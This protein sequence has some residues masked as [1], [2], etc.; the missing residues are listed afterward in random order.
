MKHYTRRAYEAY[1]TIILA[2]GAFPQSAKTIEVLQAWEDNPQ[3]KL[4]ACCDGAVNS[5]MAYTEHLPNIV[6]GDLD[7]LSCELRERLA[8]RLVHIAEQDTN[9]LAKTLRHLS[10]TLGRRELVLLGITGK[11]EDHTLGNL[12]LLP[13][14]ADLV[15]ELVVLTDTG[16]F[17]LIKEDCTMEVGRGTQLSVFNFSQTPISLSGVH[18]SLEDYTLPYLWSGTLNRAD[19]DVI[20]I[21][22]S[23]PILVFIADE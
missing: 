11:R 21:K 12:A 9:D 1:S 8:E 14:Y 19:A 17:R 16:H 7:S 5:L 10:H 4:L 22:T 6:V 3:T 15:D 2:N 20:T 13:T 23:S 18:W